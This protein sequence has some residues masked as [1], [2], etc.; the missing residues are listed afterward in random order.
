M[1]IVAMI[2]TLILGIESLCISH[3]LCPSNFASDRWSSSLQLGWE[4]NHAAFYQ[5]V[6]VVADGNA[7]RLVPT[8]Q[9]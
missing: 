3:E 1:A 7:A 2:H 9:P 6:T 5:L 4:L 8:L